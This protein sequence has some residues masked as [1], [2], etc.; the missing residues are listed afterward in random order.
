MKKYLPSQNIYRQNFLNFWLFLKKTGD[1]TIKHF[2]WYGCENGFKAGFKTKFAT[3]FSNHKMLK[4]GTFYI[5][6]TL[7]VEFFLKTHIKSQQNRKEGD[8]LI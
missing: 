2:D 7:F 8:G 3:L 5:I 4:S 6:S 1:L